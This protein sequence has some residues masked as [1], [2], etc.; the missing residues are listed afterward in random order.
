MRNKFILNLEM[1]PN[2]YPVYAPYRPMDPYMYYPY[3]PSPVILQP[4]QMYYDPNIPR[5]HPTNPNPNQSPRPY[6]PNQFIPK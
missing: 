1:M 3:Y 2:G 4:M 5:T 6:Y